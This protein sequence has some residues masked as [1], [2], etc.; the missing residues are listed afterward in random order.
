VLFNASATA[1]VFGNVYIDN[2]NLSLTP[3]PEPNFMAFLVPACSVFALHRW[4]RISGRSSI[5]PESLV[6][7]GGIL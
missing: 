5:K 7:P 3:V 4:R 2:V 1:S 6:K